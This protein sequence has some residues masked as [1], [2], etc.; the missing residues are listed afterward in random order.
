MAENALT[1]VILVH[2]RPMIYLLRLISLIC[3]FFF[4]SIGNDCALQNKEGEKVH[5]SEDCSFYCQTLHCP[6]T[7]DFS[8]QTMSSLL[9][10]KLIAKKCFLVL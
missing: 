5:D 6:S 1:F 8:G 9:L 2:E 7:R 4:F 3:I 10:D